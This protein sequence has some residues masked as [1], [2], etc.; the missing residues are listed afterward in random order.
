MDSQEIEHRKRAYAETK[1]VRPSLDIL[2]VEDNPGDVE[3]IKDLIQTSGI[4]FTITHVSTLRE[5]LI[6]CI[7]NVYDVILDRK[8]VV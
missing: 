6:C 3:L 2:L 1:V 8:S 4:D 7:D 5:T